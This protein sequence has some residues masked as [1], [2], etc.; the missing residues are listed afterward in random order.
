MLC[1]FIFEC[2][3][4]RPVFFGSLFPVAEVV[5][6]SALSVPLMSTF[7]PIIDQFS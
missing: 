5:R 3:S 7:S 1:E 2:V 6:S 4:Q